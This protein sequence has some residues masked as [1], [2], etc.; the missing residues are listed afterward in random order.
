MTMKQDGQWWWTMIMWLREA[1]PENI[2]GM[3]Q[4]QL[5]HNEVL[6]WLFIDQSGW[7]SSEHAQH[8]AS[9]L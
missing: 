7:N 5:V 1:C 3:E 6:I 4:T 8:S 9:S 2:H